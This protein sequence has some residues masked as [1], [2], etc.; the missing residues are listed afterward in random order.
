M[1]RVSKYSKDF[2]VYA[3][4]FLREGM[5][6]SVCA[7]KLGV[8]TSTFEEYK[9][10]YPEFQEAIKRGKAPVDFEVE[11]A[12]LKRA[13][14]YTFEEKSTT[15]KIMPDG[16]GV[17]AEIKKTIKEVPPDVGA[18]AFWLKNRRPEKWRESKHIDVSAS[19]AI[20]KIPSKEPLND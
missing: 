4:M 2:P 8:H 14:G 10:R 5:T 6:E 7:K 13:K 18:I 20:I 16:S 11:C 19:Q 3:E 15:T 12:L 17:V 1:G 9:N